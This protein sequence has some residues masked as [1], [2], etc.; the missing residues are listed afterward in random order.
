MYL[1]ASNL[2]GWAMFQKLPVSGFKWKKSVSKFG[3]EFIKSYDE[4]SNR[5]CI[6][7][8]DVE[9]PKDLRN[10]YSDLPFLSERIEF[11][12]CSKLLWNFYDKKE[13][14]THIRYLKQALNLGLILKKVH[15]VIR[16]NQEGWLKP[17]I[18]KN[19]NLRIKAKK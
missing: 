17:Y 8:V 16:F 6:P 15:R 5:R 13:Y 1:D 19:T 11:K 3:E 9:Y 7:E 14:V 18:E 4:D 10:L 12:K 2:Y